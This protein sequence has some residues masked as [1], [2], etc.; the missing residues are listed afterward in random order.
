MDVG[1]SVITPEV[2]IR[3]NLPVPLSV[4][5]SA[6][7]GPVVMSH[8][9]LYDAGTGYAVIA[10]DVVILPILPELVSVNQ[11]APSGP[12]VMPVSPMVAAGAM[13]YSVIVPPVV[14]RS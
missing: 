12:A 4:N 7:S 2:V 11:S 14:M 6:P 3:P 9:P 10:P 1:Y 5:H 13:G 8:G